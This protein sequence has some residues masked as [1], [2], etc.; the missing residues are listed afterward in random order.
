MAQARA[1]GAAVAAA[2]AAAAPS[3][4]AT[5][6]AA[7][8]AATPAPAPSP[9]TVRPAPAP[10]L[11]VALDMVPLAVGVLMHRYSLP[12]QA[13]YER[14]HRLAGDEGRSLAEQAGRLVEA[15]ELLARGQ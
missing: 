1:R 2:P 14:L 5:A 11:P 3:A 4:A 8:V 10:A 13:A 6:P 7:P 9:E 12:R 15:V